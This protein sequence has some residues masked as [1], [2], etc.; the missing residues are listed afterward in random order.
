MVTYQYRCSRC[1]DVDIRRP[2]GAATSRERCPRCGTDAR[3][4]YTSPRTRLV[5]PAL[6]AALDTAGASA[7]RPQVVTREPAPER[8]RRFA[9]PMHAKLPRP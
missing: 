7:E 6:V 3:R 5:A 1:G 8:P 4:V 2:M 9:H